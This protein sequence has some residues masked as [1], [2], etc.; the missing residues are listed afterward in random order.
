MSAPPLV[1][2]IIPTHNRPD[3]LKRAVDS[4]KKQTYVN[5]EIIVVDDA[6]DPRVMDL[7]SED[8]TVKLLVNETNRR[9]CYS[10]NRGLTESKGEFV[11]FLDDDD[12]LYPTK[13]EKQVGLFAKNP[14]HIERLG[15][16]VCHTNDGRMGFNVIK[17]NKVRGDIHKRLL[18]KFLIDGI[19]TV[20]YKKEALQKVNGFDEELVSNHE[21]DLQIRISESYEVD[22]IDEVLTEEFQSTNQISV[23]FDMKI[24]GAKQLYAK[25]KN[26]FKKQGYLFFLKIWIKYRLLAI[27]FWM[28]KIVG[29]KVYNRFLR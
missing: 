11:N 2:V 12:I 14:H 25:H 15:F 27:K 24:K 13:I 21:Y 29:V 28:A 8:E 5:I 18:E 10:R 9:S 6:N 26:V 16:V 20:L 23:N 22:F 1:S 19:E 3:L 17:Y 4:V 7:F